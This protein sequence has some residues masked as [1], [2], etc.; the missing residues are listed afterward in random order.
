M[1]SESILTI[2]LCTFMSKGIEEYY[3]CHL[4]A[5]NRRGALPPSFFKQGDLSH[6]C[7]PGSYAP[8]WIPLAPHKSADFATHNVP[9]LPRHRDQHN[10]HGT[11]AWANCDNEAVVAV[12]EYFSFLPNKISSLTTGHINPIYTGTL[13]RIRNWIKQIPLGVNWIHTLLWAM[14]VSSTNVNVLLV[15]TSLN[16]M[17][18]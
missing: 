6:P 11:S 1:H 17:A 14:N 8:G 16:R 3:H 4:L 12:I 9:N 10:G 18:N 13:I 2:A 15:R 5:L 7:P